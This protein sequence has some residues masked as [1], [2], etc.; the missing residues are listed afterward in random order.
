M[1]HSVRALVFANGALDPGP[2]VSR[3]LEEAG[4]GALAIAADGGAQHLLALG[5]RPH[6]II[7]DMDSVPDDLLAQ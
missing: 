1:S 3:A 5:L 7:G 4:P 6:A 2:M